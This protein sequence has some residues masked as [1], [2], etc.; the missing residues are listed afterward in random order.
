MTIILLLAF[1]T[2]LVAALERHHRHTWNL[3]HAPHGADSTI[4]F[5]DLDH[6]WD[7]VLHDADARR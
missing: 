5:T 4:A 6:D 2:A 1:V 7:R 3:P